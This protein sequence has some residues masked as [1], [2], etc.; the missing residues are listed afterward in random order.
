MRQATIQTIKSKSERLTNAPLQN[1]NYCHSKLYQTHNIT[2]A[3]VAWSNVSKFIRAL[4]QKSHIIN[5]SRA[6]SY[7][8]HSI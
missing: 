3:L 4:Q 5:K 2:K 6:H 8:H 7:K 1:L